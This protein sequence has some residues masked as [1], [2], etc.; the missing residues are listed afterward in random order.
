MTGM[1]YIDG[2]P[3]VWGRRATEDKDFDGSVH[4]MMGSSSWV[5]PHCGAHLRKS[6]ETNLEICLNACH[7]TAPQ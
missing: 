4:E 2:V 5:C 7:L 3:H 1:S 6:S